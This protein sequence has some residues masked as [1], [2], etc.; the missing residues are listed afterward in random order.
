MHQAKP[1]IVK[2][3]P[4]AFSH[5]QAMIS[6]ASKIKEGIRW[7]RK[8]VGSERESSANRL[9]KRIARMQMILGDQ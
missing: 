8:A 9:T 7:I 3:I 2:I 4:P 6:M 1:A 5:L